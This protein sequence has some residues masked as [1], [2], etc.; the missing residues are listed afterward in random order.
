MLGT[1]GIYKGDQIGQDGDWY[2]VSYLEHAPFTE[3]TVNGAVMF[4]MLP[5]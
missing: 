3:N 5:L 2:L 4:G 1:C